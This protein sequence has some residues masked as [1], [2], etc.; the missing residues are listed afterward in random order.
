MLP[1][2]GPG[3]GPPRPP[4]RGAPGRGAPGPWLPWPGAPCPAVPCPAPPGPELPGPEPPGRGPAGRGPGTGLRPGAA[5]RA[6]GPPSEGTGGTGARG[7]DGAGAPEPVLAAGRAT[8][9]GAGAAGLPAAGLA[10]G[11]LGLASGRSLTWGPDAAGACGRAG[12]G[13]GTGRPLPLPSA[14]RAGAGAPGPCDPRPGALDPWAENSF[15]SLRTTGA[16]MV[17]DAERTNSPISWSLAITA[18]LSTPNSFASS[19]TRTFATALPLSARLRRAIVADPGQRVLRP[20]SASG[21]HRRVLIARSSQLIPLSRHCC[22][23]SFDRLTCRGRPR[24]LTRPPIRAAAT[25]SRQVV[26]ER[27]G[28]KRGRLPQRPR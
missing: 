22:R 17:D 18:L 21:S 16:S 24:G 25:S 19:Y 27:S 2:R 8:S 20:A 9:P 7:V 1:G 14:G 23:F 6:A 12:P 13:R 26:L 10:A 4:G 15:L 3:R 28:T 5:G 11:G